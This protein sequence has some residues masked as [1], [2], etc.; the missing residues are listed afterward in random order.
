MKVEIHSDIVC[1]WCYIGERRL[2]RVLERL[3][4]PEEVEVVFRPF[5]L[6]PDAPTT[7]V[8]TAQYL[9]ERFGGLAGA[10]Q[11]RVSAAG[12]AEGIAFA[13]DRALSVNTRT[14]HRLLGLAEREH[15]PEVQRALVERLFD[16]HFSR[17]GDLSD[18]ERLADEAEA[19][20]MDRSR[21]EAYLASREG[22]EELERD[23]QRAR[24]VGVR[25]VPTF[26]FDETWAIEGAQPIEVF[27]RALEQVARP[28]SSA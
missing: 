1:P 19:V 17:G 13:W 2:A 21:V 12:E 15:G 8:P 7:A 9:E 18:L 25:A 10:M 20:G 11:D 6:D 4:D 26:V 22:I 5:Q 23:L 3:E 28:G 14:A 27:R 24:E 16:L